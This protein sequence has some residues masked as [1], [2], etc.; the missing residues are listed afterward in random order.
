MSGFD[1]SEGQAHVRIAN[2]ARG[3]GQHMEAAQHYAT[4]ERYF[5]AYGSESLADWAGAKA[6]EQAEL[7]RQAERFA[8]L[9]APVNTSALVD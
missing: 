7:A 1:Y 6:V 9:S 3:I 4:A 2:R 8:R 5:R